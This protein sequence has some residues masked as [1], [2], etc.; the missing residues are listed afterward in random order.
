MKKPVLLIAVFACL[1]IAVS[2]CKPHAE[3]V[4]EKTYVSEDDAQDGTSIENAVVIQQSSESEGVAAEYE[5]LKKHYPGYSLVRQTP[6][7][8]NG[9]SYDKVEIKLADGSTKT[10][11]FD[12]SNFFGKF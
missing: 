1:A 6:F 8:Q 11:Y 5:W 9:K 12:I 2:N 4:G 3:I 10:V 7:K